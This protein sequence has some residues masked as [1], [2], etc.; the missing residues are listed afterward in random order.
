M[1]N[2]NSF[3]GTDSQSPQIHIQRRNFLKSISILV[4]GLSISRLSVM[5]GPFSV[6]DLNKAVPLDKKLNEAWVKAL[7]DHGLP[8]I[9]KGVELNYIGMPVGG[10]CTGQVYLGGDG[11]LWRWDI[12]NK[13]HGTGDRNYA[14]PLLPDYPLEQSFTISIAGKTWSIDRNG[15]ANVSFMGQYPI[16][17]VHYQDDSIPVEITLEAFSPF[18]PLASDDSGLPVVIMQFTVKNTSSKPVDA[19]LTGLL[20]NGVCLDNRA[21]FSGKRINKIINNN[22]F[23]FLECSV[24]KDVITGN[25]RPDKTFEDWNKTS[26]T[27]WTAEGTAFGNGPIKKTDIPSYQGDVGGDTEQ[28]VNSHA[29]APGTSTQDKDKAKGKLISNLFTIDRNYINF[30]IGGG[31]HKGQT[32]INLIVDSKVVQTMAGQDNNQMTLQSFYVKDFTGREAHLEIVDSFEGGWGNIGIGKITFSDSPGASTNME[33]LP[34]YGT[35]GLALL[36]N[37]AEIVENNQPNAI[38]SEKTSGQLGRKLILAPKQSSKVTFLISWFFPN[39][40][41]NKVGSGRY[42]S[43]KFNSAFSVAN[44]VSSNFD[45]LDKLTKLWRDTWYNSTLPF[46]FLDRTFVNTSTLATSTCYRYANGRFWAWEGVGCCQGTCTHVWHYAQAMARIFPDIERDTR[47]RVD[48][49][50]SL[51]QETGISGFRGEYD[52]GLAIDGQSGTILRIY[53]EHQMSMDNT[54]LKTNWNNIKLM[55]N[56][57][58]S[59]DSNNDG[60]LEGDQMN[61]LDRPWFGKISWL[62]SIYLAALRAGEAMATEMGEPDFATRCRQIIEKGMKNIDE[63]L[64]NGEYYY[65][66]GEPGKAGEVGSYNGCEIDQVLG[67]SWVFQVGLDRVLSEKNTKTALESLWKYNFALDAGL[68]RKTQGSGRVY[69]MEGEAG[70]LMCSWPKG[71]SKRVKVSYDFYFNECMTGFEYQAAGHMIWEGML[72]KGLAVTKAIHDRYHA[73]K[74]NPWNEVECGDHYARAMASYGVFL[75]A[76]GFEYHGPQGMIGF[77]PKI[78]PENFKSIFTSAEGWGLFSQNR[79]SGKQVSKIE[80]KYGQMKMQTFRLE[81]GENYEP[82]SVKVTLKSGRKIISQTHK[83]EGRKIIIT[84]DN[85]PVIIT[86]NSDIVADITFKKFTPTTSINEM[87]TETGMF[88]NPIS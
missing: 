68:Y 46:W 53:R 25:E 39:L 8:T 19:N 86:E 30:W 43:N 60:I 66:T 18:I 23:T 75:A 55:F 24:E 48:L 47:Q 31:S 26:Y 51:N 3:D 82:K 12:F 61:T 62:S 78:T 64:F 42:Y 49:G 44:Y 6:A 22:G 58:F 80:I 27:N 56:P 83:M 40:V 67:Q 45:R 77:A 1:E 29:T 76:C 87:E 14:N 84:V 54:F 16:G 28:V 32:C 81:L 7:Y 69:A 38:L 33:N 73:S 79:T 71:D 4:G 36:G 52:R 10:I 65:Q 50:L 15:F 5:A 72:E 20:E 74:R 2:K 70:L 63:Q 88:P 9:Y 41:D 13:K 35:M 57:L 59:R 34:D 37:P 11:R 21:T 85:S 17:E